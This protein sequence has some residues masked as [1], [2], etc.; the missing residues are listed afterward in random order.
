MELRVTLGPDNSLRLILP[1]G[2]ALDVGNTVAS[3]RFIQRILMDAKKKEERSGYIREFP[4]QHVIDIWKREEA[5]Q[6]VEASKD[7]FKDLGIDLETL[8]ISL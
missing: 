6:Q 8:D 4:T 7:R 3:L 1:Q 5:R 2:R